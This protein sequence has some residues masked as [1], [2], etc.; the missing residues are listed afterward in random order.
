MNNSGKMN[1]VPRLY[2]VLLS[3]LLK[4]AEMT[5]HEPFTKSLDL[6]VIVAVPS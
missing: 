3:F 4:V 1:R 6:V 5:R 2:L